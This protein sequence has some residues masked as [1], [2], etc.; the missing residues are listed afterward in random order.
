MVEPAVRKEIVG[1]LRSV[2]EAED[3]R[4]IYACESGSRAWGFASADS[5]YDVRFIYVHQANWYLSI[6]DAKDVVEHTDGLLD[7]SGWDI[8]KA[9]RLLRRSNPPLLEW[10][11]SPIVYLEEPVIVGRI[12]D[13]ASE[14]FSPRSCLHHYLHMAEGNYR[15]YLRGT[16]VKTKKYFYVLRPI[17]A[18][19]W[20]EDRNTTPPMEFERLVEAQGLDK[21][22][23]SEI[24]CLLR[25]KKAGEEMDT[26]PRI[27]VI[28]EFVEASLARFESSVKHI[29]SAVT[30]DTGVL[31]SLFRE[32]LASV[33]T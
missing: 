15:E 17:L 27:A 24:D 3:I 6:D 18:C 9:L 5:D 12:R 25:G 21:P 20:I 22:L 26:G 1:R 14:F 2:E 4:V 7:L 33:W 29:A 23:A 8:R 11:R 30:P 10:L 28:N 19:M 16:E 31:N 32:L 13:L